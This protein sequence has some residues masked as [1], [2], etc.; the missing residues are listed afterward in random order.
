MAAPQWAGFLA[1]VAEARMKTGRGDL[2]FLNPVIYGLNSSQRAS[3]FNDVTSGK[4][5]VYKCT[6][7]WDAVTGWG[8]MQ[9][10]NFLNYLQTR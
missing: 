5:G 8:S 4:N 6:T 1:L 2:G 10:S 9:A 7:G 3:M